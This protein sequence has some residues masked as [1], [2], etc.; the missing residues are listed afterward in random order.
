[1][2]EKIRAF[3]RNEGLRQIAKY[4]RK[5]IPLSLAI[6]GGLSLFIILGCMA[7]GKLE[8]LIVSMNIRYNSPA[9]VT[10]MVIFIVVQI[11]AAGYG[12]FLSI[13][14]YKRPGGRGMFSTSYPKGNSYKALSS[15][16]MKNRQK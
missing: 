12:A 14:E 8:D 5:P 4:T 15:K 13:R 6:A 7:A 10:L 9:I 2:L 3:T 1:M 11:G 16:L